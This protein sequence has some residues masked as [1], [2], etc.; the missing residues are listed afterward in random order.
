MLHVNLLVPAGIHRSISVMQIIGTVFSQ[1]YQN[2]QNLSDRITSVDVS[3]DVNVVSLHAL[4][5]HE[6]A[7]PVI[8]TI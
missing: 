1:S 3:L 5:A 7:I 8:M 4:H 6:D 2:I